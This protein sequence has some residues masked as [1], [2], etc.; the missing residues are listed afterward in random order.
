MRL[1]ERL[2]E[3]LWSL[4]DRDQVHVIR[5]EA[6]AQQ[7]ESIKLRIFPQQ[8]KVSDAVRIAGQNHLSRIPALRN[9]MRNADDHDTRQPSHKK[10]LTGMTRSAHGDGLAL[11]L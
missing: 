6:V 8:L 4:R 9:M 5:H 7:A 11:P 1:F 10:K 3:S 2:R